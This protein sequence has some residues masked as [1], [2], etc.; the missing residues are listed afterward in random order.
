MQIYKIRNIKAPTDFIIIMLYISLIFLIDT[1]FLTYE[2]VSY[3]GQKN[4]RA[5]TLVILR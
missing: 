3:S 5:C 2:A 4:L 1:L